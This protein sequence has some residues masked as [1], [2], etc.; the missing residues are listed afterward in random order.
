M[1]RPASLL[2]PWRLSTPRSGQGDLSPCLGPATGL[3][4]D[5][6]DGTLTRWRGAARRD[7]LALS[8]SAVLFVTAHHAPILPEPKSLSQRVVAADLDPW[9]SGGGRDRQGQ[10]GQP[11]AAAVAQVD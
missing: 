3:S 11:V 4:G 8:G 7:P 5:Y 9:P 2:P 6:P 1:L 10:H